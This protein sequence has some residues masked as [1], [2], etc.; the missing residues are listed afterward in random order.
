MPAVRPP[1]GLANF[2]DS[3]FTPPRCTGQF[4]GRTAGGGG[5]MSGASKPEL[6]LW[7][8]HRD[9]SAPNNVSSILA[10]GDVPPP[11]A[12]TMFR[13]RAPISTVTWSV[14][15]IGAEFQGAAWHL[16][17]AGTE[18]IGHGYSAQRMTLWNARGEPVLSG[19][20]AIA[21]FG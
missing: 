11:A 7:L 14:D 1:E 3:P 2:F 17:H 13:S 10:L 15:V 18:T 19:R 9:P 6:L 4:E 16:A 5:P 20:Q 12:I 8:R 21:V